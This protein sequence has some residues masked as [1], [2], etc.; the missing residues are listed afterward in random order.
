LKTKLLTLALFIFIMP[1][2]LKAQTLNPFYQN[3]VS[4]VSYDSLLFSLEN[5]ENLGVKQPGTQALDNTK[6]RIISKYTWE[7]YNNISL[8]TF[9]NSGHTMYNIVITKTGSLYSNKYV[10][11]DGHYDT[12]TGTGTNDN[13]S[14]TSIIME[15]ARLLKNVNTEYS[16][17]F[18]HF[19]AEE[20]GMVGSGHYVSNVVSPQNMQIR[21]VF[22]IDEVGGVA[23]FPNDTIKCESDQSSPGSN[24]ATSAAFTDTLA[25]LTHL[26]SNLKTAITNAYGSDYMPFQSNGNIITG[27]YEYRESSVP[28]TS[29]DLLINLD[30]SYVYEVAKAATAATL[31][32]ARAYDTTTG[33]N[34]LQP[35]AEDISIFPNPFNSS[36]YISTSG[37]QETHHLVLFDALGQKILSKEFSSNCEIAF[38]CAGISIYF[39]NI[40]NESGEVIKSGKLLHVEK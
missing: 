29:N 9:T 32:F 26:Y 21:I 25:T 16:I 7:G 35:T 38:P 36:F 19:S 33:F 40:I 37:T 3:I 24:N 31:Y 5:F 15:I 28:H 27:L 1:C 6:N 20:E 18:I 10:I 4:N 14:G 17:R 30:T 39:Y 2:M 22:N 23:G 8:D 12:R 13:G 11:V 34:E